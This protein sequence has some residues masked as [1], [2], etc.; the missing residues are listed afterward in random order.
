M[1]AGLVD[2]SID[3][4]IVVGVAARAHGSPL[5]T[6]DLDICYEGSDANT[7]RIIG[8]VTRWQAYPRGWEPGL[9]FELDTRTLRITPVLTMVTSQ[10]WLD[11]RDRVDGVGD[12]LAVQK[13]S[14]RMDIFDRS[15]SVLT[16]DALLAA[17]RATGREKDKLQLPVQEGLRALHKQEGP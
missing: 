16:L 8:L 10:G 9:P 17:K 3:F 5:F 6:G 12:C 15:V 14:S 11:L 2:A 1:I 4:V 13:N 7:E